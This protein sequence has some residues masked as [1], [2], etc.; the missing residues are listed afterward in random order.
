MIEAPPV[1]LLRG[2]LHAVSCP[3]ALVAGGVLA[4]L[5]PTPRA[6]LALVVMSVGFAMIFGTSGAYHRLPWSPRWRRRLRQADHS[7]IFVGMAST[8]TAIWLVAL[9][10][11]VADIV[12]VYVWIA[13]L[14]GI[15]AKALWLDASASRHWLGYVAFGL[16]GLAVV[17]GLWSTMGP[18]GVVLMLLGGV[19]FGAGGAA[20]AIGRPN[21]IP[22]WFGHHEVFHAGTVV[23]CALYLS[24]LA[25]FALR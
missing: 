22:R 5:A 24:A 10:G 18:I 19:A 23:G 21:P 20:Y 13:A 15:V 8:Y 9:D 12:L 6:A 14:A 7:M 16:V 3:V 1:P 4:W 11:I 2:L 25:H 17:P